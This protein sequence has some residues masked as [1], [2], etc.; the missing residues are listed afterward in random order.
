MST[1]K[2]RVRFADSDSD[3]DSDNE[4]Q[5]NRAFADNFERSRARALVDKRMS[6]RSM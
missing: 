4:L 3:S 6:L 1:E 2:K 5:I